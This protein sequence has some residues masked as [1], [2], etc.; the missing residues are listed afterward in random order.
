VISQFR[1]EKAR[2]AGGRVGGMCGRVRGGAGVAGVQMAPL[3][4]AR[5]WRVMGARSQTDLAVTGAT[6]LY[7]CTIHVRFHRFSALRFK[8]IGKGFAGFWRFC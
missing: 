7:R 3:T 6:F 4:A 5:R 1:R 2:L 8:K